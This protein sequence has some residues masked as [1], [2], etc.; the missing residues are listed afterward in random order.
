MKI[1]NIFLPV[2]A[3]VFI[4]D[5]SNTA[6]AAPRAGTVVIETTIPWAAAWPKL[7]AAIQHNRM[8]IVSR[9]SASAGARSR[10]VTLPGNMVIGVFR[11]D[12]AVRMLAASVE[13]GVEAPLRFY[14]TENTNGTTRL[15]YRKPGAVFAPYGSSDL[16]K[17]ARELDEIFR[18]IAAEATR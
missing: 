15:S 4:L 5:L 13:A 17:L 1:F 9:A 16:D 8:G 6:M 11:N 18:A 3:C 7:Q 14:L 2:L 12:F 10:G